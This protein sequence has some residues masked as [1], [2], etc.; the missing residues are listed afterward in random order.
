MLVRRLLPLLHP[1]L[2]IRNTVRLSS[3][4]FSCASEAVHIWTASCQAAA[5]PFGL[6]R[7]LREQ[8]PSWQECK[9]VPVALQYSFFL[10]LFWS[11]FRQYSFLVRRAPFASSA[12]RH[13]VTIA[14]PA[15]SI[16]RTL[17]WVSFSYPFLSEF[18]ASAGT[19]AARFAVTASAAGGAAL[20]LSAGGRLMGKTICLFRKAESRGDVGVRGC[21]F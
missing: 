16:V 7:F 2:R 19:A 1:A 15:P 4:L 18:P 20:D 10:L 11:F 9:I 21:F 5:V 17:V 12:H 3:P 14:E 13:R 8:Y 6:L